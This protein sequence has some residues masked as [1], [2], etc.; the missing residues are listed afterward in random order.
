MGPVHLL[1]GF[2]VRSPL[3]VQ[4][5]S[6]VSAAL[7]L[8]HPSTPFP[9]LPMN[10]QGRAKASTAAPRHESRKTPQQPKVDQSRTTNTNQNRDLKYDG[11]YGLLRRFLPKTHCVSPRTHHAGRRHNITH[12]RHHPLTLRLLFH[13]K[14][15]RGLSQRFPSTTTHLGD[16]AIPRPSFYWFPRHEN[17][18]HY[19]L[20]PTPQINVHRKTPPKVL[21]GLPIAIRCFTKISRPRKSPSK[22]K[23]A[24]GYNPPNS[25]CYQGRKLSIAIRCVVVSPRLSLGALDSRLARHTTNN[26]Y[27]PRSSQDHHAPRPSAYRAP[28]QPRPMWR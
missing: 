4:L 19:E 27:P 2:V 12:T 24:K 17:H 14:F 6:H 10:P 16:T 20:L 5:R 3:F 23:G 26:V 11:F 18:H 15:Q 8:S 22:T 1:V 21:Q 28:T 25:S 7:R 13:Q 9:F